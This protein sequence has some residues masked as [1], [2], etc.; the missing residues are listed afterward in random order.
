V[1]LM[2]GSYFPAGWMHVERRFSVPLTDPVYGLVQ[3]P[4]VLLTHRVVLS[5]A[6]GGTT[7]PVYCLVDIDSSVQPVHR[8]CGGSSVHHRD[9]GILVIVP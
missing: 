2:T 1:E 3:R 6:W 8:D 9:R 5:N 7:V 4:Q